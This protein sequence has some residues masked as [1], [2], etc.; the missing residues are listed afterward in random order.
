MSNAL[1]VDFVVGQESCVV[2]LPISQVNHPLRRQGIWGYQAML[3]R[4]K[5]L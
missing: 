3:R 5:Q 4:F 2:S 1:P